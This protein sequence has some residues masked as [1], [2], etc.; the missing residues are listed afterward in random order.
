[1]TSGPNF[2][3]SALTGSNFRKTYSKFV[4]DVSKPLLNRAIK[5]Q[6]PPGS[7]FKPLGALVAL[8][9]G[10]ITPS[11]GYPCGGRYYACG[12][13]K[14][15]C[16]HNNPGHAANLQ[17]AIA[18][19]CNSYFTHLYR[20]TVDYVLILISKYNNSLRNYLQTKWEP[21]WHWNLKLGE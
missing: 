15:A 3:P 16:S 8:D 20:M 10:L 9:E 14:P 6:Y 2:S 13:G 18:N 17:L 19:S 21:L 4:L 7:T 11:F 5:G 1:M 12:H